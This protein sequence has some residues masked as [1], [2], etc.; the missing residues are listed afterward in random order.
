M[1]P[2]GVIRRLF[3]SM[4]LLAAAGLWTTV[5]AAVEAPY[6]ELEFLP[7]DNRVSLTSG[8]MR[9]LTLEGTATS[10]FADAVSILD[11]LNA[12]FLLT[13]MITSSVDGGGGN[14]IHFTAGGM[15]TIG[16]GGSLLTASASNI[17]LTSTNGNQHVLGAD[18]TY[19]FGSLVSGGSGSG[20]IEGV[21]TGPEA[22]LDSAFT[23]VGTESLNA[24]VGAVV[25]VPAAALLLGSALAGLLG[26][27][28]R[29]N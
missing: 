7:G 4:L 26:F 29:N 24:K 25:P 19:T 11:T 9:T 17:S 14:Y 8:I 22:S 27:R 2:F 5:H 28:I 1:K 16:D 21:F 12:P 20:R 6:V 10:L 3:A 18:L 15:L 23:S 13:T